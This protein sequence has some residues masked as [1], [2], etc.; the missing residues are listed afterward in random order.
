MTLFG[1][2]MNIPV[3]F[4]RGEFKNESE[5]LRYKEGHRDA[6]HEAAQIAIEGDRAIQLLSEIGDYYLDEIQSEDLVEK[7]KAFMEQ[8]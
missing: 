7:I 5:Y 1:E 4:S 6:R 3:E 8:R 2:I